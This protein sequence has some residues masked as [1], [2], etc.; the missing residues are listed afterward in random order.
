MHRIFLYKLLVNLKS[1]DIIEINVDDL[2]EAHKVFINILDEYNLKKYSRLFKNATRFVSHFIYIFGDYELG[3]YNNLNRIL[4]FDNNPIIIDS[5]I[6]CEIDISNE[7]IYELSMILSLQ[8][9]ENKTLKKQ[10]IN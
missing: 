2:Y 7:L 9:K 5:L 6:K 1:Q 3:I 10:L 4:T 8:L